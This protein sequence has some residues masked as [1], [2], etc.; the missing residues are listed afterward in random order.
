MMW[1]EEVKDIERRTES[2]GK[3]NRRIWKY[4]QRDMD[5]NSE[6]HKKKK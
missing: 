2:Y 4:E 1:N 3:K 6:Q 5:R